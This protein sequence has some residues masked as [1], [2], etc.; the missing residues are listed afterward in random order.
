MPQAWRLA[1]RYWGGWE[2][3][4]EFIGSGG[5]AVASGLQN[6]H[7][8]G[9]SGSTA[10]QGGASVSRGVCQPPGSQQQPGCLFSAEA[11]GG[12][13]V[14]LGYL[15]PPL[16]GLDGVALQVGSYRQLPILVTA[17]CTPH[18]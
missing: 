4:L 5:P 3:G 17:L 11:R 1:T 10:P 6:S 9:A 7:Q 2:G 13:L 12:P 16:M 18:K 15:R 8:L 14:M